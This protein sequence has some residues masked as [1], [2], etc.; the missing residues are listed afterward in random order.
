MKKFLKEV[1][2]FMI[3]DDLTKDWTDK[4]WGSPFLIWL[5]PFGAIV[6]FADVFTLPL[7]VP[8]WAIRKVF[9]KIFK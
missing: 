3:V 1:R 7:T 8:I 2:P 5:A 6:V 9:R 4:D